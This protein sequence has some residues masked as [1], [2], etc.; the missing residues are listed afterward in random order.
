MKAALVAV[1][2]ASASLRQPTPASMDL[3][4][5]D[6][7]GSELQESYAWA[8]F[9]LARLAANGVVSNDQTMLG[10]GAGL[11]LYE[12]ALIDFGH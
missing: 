7:L 10:V 2:I 3:K 8:G 12:R 11:H 4:M 6:Y 1:Q 5:R 9:G